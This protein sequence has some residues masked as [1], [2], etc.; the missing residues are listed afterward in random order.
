MYYD[1]E[2]KLAEMCRSEAEIEELQTDSEQLKR[3]YSISEGCDDIV[4]EAY[5]RLSD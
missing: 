3:L 2:D 1:K 4:L 5:L